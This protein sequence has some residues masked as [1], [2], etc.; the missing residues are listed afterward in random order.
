[1]S[2]D[3]GAYSNP[4]VD[5]FTQQTDTTDG[6]VQLDVAKTFWVGFMLVS[7][8]VGSALTLSGGAVVLF[9]LTTIVTLC[10][11]HS[12]G[13]HRRFIHRSFECPKWLEYFLVHLGVV[14]GLAGPYGMLVTHDTRDWA[15]RQ[16]RCHEYFSHGRP[17]YH[18][19]YWQVFCSIR[20]HHPLEFQIEEDI[21]EDRVYRWMEKTWMLQQLPWAIAFYLL[22]GWGWVFW[23]ICSRV[24][25]SIVG[26]WLVGYFAHNKG[27]MNWRVQHAAVQGYNV[28]WCALITMGESWHNNH[29]A[30]PGS[31]RIGL[32]PGQWDPGWWV[33]CALER[34]GLVKNLKTPDLLEIRTDLVTLNH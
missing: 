28:R 3:S 2:R 19:F 9:V 10:L 7:G 18:D 12:I 11:G 1:M 26:H 20:L 4:R 33:L 14:V 27:G 30:F 13:M 16:T 23:G 29:H 22:G 15:Q 25:V 31:A 32:K 6:Q 8:T 34:V 21:V 24:S 17:W 5:G